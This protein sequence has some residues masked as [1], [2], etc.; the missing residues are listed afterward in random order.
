MRRLLA[1]VLAAALILSFAS[2]TG[3][4]NPG[5]GDTVANTNNSSSSASTGLE[6]FVSDLTSSGFEFTESV[7]SDGNIIIDMETPN[8]D[9]DDPVGD[10]TARP[11]VP[12]IDNMP[13]EDETEETPSV[14]T[15]STPSVDSTVTPPGNNTVSSTP[16][17]TTKPTYTYTSGQKHTAVGLH[18]RFL[19]NT[20]NADEKAFYNAIDTAVRNLESRVWTDKYPYENNLYFVYYIYMFDNPEHFYLGNSLTIVSQGGRYALILG[21][22]DGVVHCKYGTAVPELNDTLRQS[23]RAKKSKFD[24]AVNR[25]VSTIPSNAPAA[26]KEKLI[27]DYIQSNCSYNESA[28]WNGFCE[29][30]WNAY[31]CI[32]NKKG[33]CEAYAEAFQ[34]LCLEVG[35]NATCITGTYSG[36]HKWSAVQLDGEWYACDLTF[37][38]PIGGGGKLYHSCFNR[39]SDWFTS[40]GYSTKSSKFKVPNCNGTK[41]SYNNYFK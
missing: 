25:I 31:G 9:P 30:N 15:V 18:S 8:E 35:I 36:S 19:Y 3:N 40:R 24:A 38:D 32:I 29:D 22:S 10:T 16:S 13:D 37:D 1:L 34:M 28:V 11:S 33:V 7:T 12:S 6:S 26:H 41:Y 20:L 14:P 5:G 39:T 4:S 17:V 23:I 27:Y 21:Y 2:C